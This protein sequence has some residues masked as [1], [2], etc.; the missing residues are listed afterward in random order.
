MHHSGL[1]RARGA[2]DCGE[3]TRVEVN[4]DVIEGGDLG[5]AHAVNLGNVSEANDLGRRWFCIHT[6]I[7]IARVARP[8]WGMPWAFPDFPRCVP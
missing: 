7:M 1:T 4:G 6:S 3:L 5:I 2:H 8:L